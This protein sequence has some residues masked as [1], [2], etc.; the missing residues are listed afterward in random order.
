MSESNIR[1]ALAEHLGAYAQ[2]ATAASRQWT[3]QLVRRVLAL[4]IAAFLT[5]LT[6]LV[7][8]FVAILASWSTPWRWW[9]IWGL[10]FLCIGSVVTGLLVARRLLRSRVAAPWT[11]LA[12]E[13]ATDLRGYG[14]KPLADAEDTSHVQG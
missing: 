6:L 13:V 7:V 9:V 1:A 5:W 8:V 12:E 10:L 14:A 11:I 3:A 4:V 2:L